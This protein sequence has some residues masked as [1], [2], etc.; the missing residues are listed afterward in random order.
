MIELRSLLSLFVGCGPD[1]AVKSAY[2]QVINLTAA[3]SLRQV[4]RILLFW[5]LRM[6]VVVGTRAGG[7]PCW[8]QV[9]SLW[10]LSNCWWYGAEEILTRKI[11]QYW[12]NIVFHLV[13]LIWSIWMIRCWFR[14]RL[15]DSEWAG[16][17]VLKTVPR[18]MVLRG[19]SRFW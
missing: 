16:L 17:R 4:G 3:G 19:W 13:V 11:M 9:S 15:S 18:I 2:G 7:A 6:I 10:L 14:V 5:C 12:W 8:W 1:Y